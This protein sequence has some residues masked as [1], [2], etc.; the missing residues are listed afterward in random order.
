M[1]SPSLQSLLLQAHVEELDRATQAYNRG[2][3]V[4]RPP[5]AR[6]STLIT[7]AINRLFAGGP[8]MNDETRQSTASNSPATA[9]PR[10]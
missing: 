2:R 1:Y 5:A 6:L 7:R 3:E 10:P 4:N 8:A 9:V